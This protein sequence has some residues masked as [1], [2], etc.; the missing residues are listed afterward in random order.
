MHRLDNNALQ[1]KFSNSAAG[2]VAAAGFGGLGTAALYAGA[3]KKAKRDHILTEF[4]AHFVPDEEFGFEKKYDDRM[5]ELV[6]QANSKPKEF[7]ARH[8]QGRREAVL[9]RIDRAYNP[10]ALER[11]CAQEIFEVPYVKVGPSEAARRNAL[12]QGNGGPYY[13][14]T[15][16][17]KPAHPHDLSKGFVFAEASKN[18]PS[19]ANPKVIYPVKSMH[20]ISSDYRKGPPLYVSRTTKP[21]EAVFGFMDAS[22]QVFAGDSQQVAGG[23]RT[24]S[25]LSTW[26]SEKAINGYWQNARSLIEKERIEAAEYLG[27]IAQKEQTIAALD[28]SALPRWQRWKK[29]PRFYK[30]VGVGLLAAGALAAV[31]TAGVN[32]GQKAAARPVT[33]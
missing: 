4:I 32:T 22:K 11:F 24:S 2:Y 23:S 9:Q 1:N 28:H 3:A 26:S 29:S 27:S 19:L 17:I 13:T 6:G 5:K 31:W 16:I 8:V 25:S 15:F 12:L 33:L 20:D 21:Q 18:G 10:D 14:K 30:W 7:F